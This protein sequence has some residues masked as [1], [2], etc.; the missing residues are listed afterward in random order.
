MLSFASAAYTADKRVIATFEANL[1]PLEGAEGHSATMAW[2]EKNPEAW[3]ASRQNLEFAEQAMPR[4]VAWI[5]T[6]PAK[7][8]FV[9]YP[10]SF[11][12]HVRVL[13]SDSFYGGDVFVFSPRHEDVCHGSSGDRVSRGGQTQHAQTLVRRFASY[14]PRPG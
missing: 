1:W 10:A 9:A 7:P 12:L 6:L 8:V 3:Q 2:W 4:Y 13:V 11:D 14:P 5:K